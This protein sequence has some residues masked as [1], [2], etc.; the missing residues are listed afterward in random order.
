MLKIEVPGVET[1][2]ERTGEFS[3]VGGCVLRLE[4]SLVSVSKWEARWEKIFLTEAPKSREETTSYFQCMSLD[5]GVDPEVFECLGASDC[6]RINRY[7]SAPMT[8]TTVSKL[9]GARRRS[10]EKVSSELI[11]Y[12]M[13]AYGIPFECQSW[14]LNR[15]LTLIEVCNAKNAPARKQSRR[16]VA[17]QNAELNRMRRQALHSSG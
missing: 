8:A 16:D 14:H 2:D 9:P 13:I 11:Y 7:I 10:P 1:F 12:W 4:H 15:L 3:H 6:E 5:E 17:A